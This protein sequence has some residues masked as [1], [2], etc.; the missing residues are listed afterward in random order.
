MSRVE[1]ESFATRVVHYYENFAERS[2]KKTYHHFLEELNRKSTK[3]GIL[4]GYKVTGKVKPER[5]T[6]SPA[7]KT[8]LRKVQRVEK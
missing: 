4:Q 6:G 5:I 8:S 3:Y 1:G 7:M 2:K